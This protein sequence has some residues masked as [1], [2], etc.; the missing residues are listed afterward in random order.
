MKPPPSLPGHFPKAAPPNTITLGV[1]AATY[2]FRGEGAQAFTP[3]QADSKLVNSV[4]EQCS[5]LCFVPFCSTFST[6]SQLLH[7]AKIGCHMLLKSQS[8]PV[9]RGVISSRAFLYIRKA[10]FSLDHIHQYW[11]TFHV[12]VARNP[13]KANSCNFQPLWEG[14]GSARWEET[15]EHFWEQRLVSHQPPF[16]PLDPWCVLLGGSMGGSWWLLYSLSIVFCT[17]GDEA[18]GYIGNV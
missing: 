1:R 18:D 10:Y 4:V 14:A 8:Y 6:Q 3:C 12:P 5:S 11:V 17:R 2:G 7:S 16:P 15:G 9:N 13:G